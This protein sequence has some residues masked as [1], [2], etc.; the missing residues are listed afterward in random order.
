MAR[1]IRTLPNRY[2][3]M[4]QVLPFQIRA[5]QGL[6]SGFGLRHT[7]VTP[8]LAGALLLLLDGKG[9]FPAA[10][11]LLAGH[12]AGAAFQRPTGCT[13]THM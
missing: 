11:T 13:H 3:A 5:Q 2:A 9:D 12:T 8:L 10:V 4:A 1:I 6:S 7:T